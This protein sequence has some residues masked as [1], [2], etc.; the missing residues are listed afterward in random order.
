MRCEISVGRY[1]ISDA[2]AISILKDAG[3][4]TDSR[5]LKLT[6]LERQHRMKADLSN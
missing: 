2:T 3:N 5:D 6:Y 1:G 4:G